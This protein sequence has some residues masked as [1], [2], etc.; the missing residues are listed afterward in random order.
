MHKDWY[1]FDEQKAFMVSRP[2]TRV[3]HEKIPPGI[4]SIDVSPKGLWF[5]PRTISAD[6]SHTLPEN[7]SQKVI[8]SVRNFRTKKDRYD[9]K[10]L[11]F[12][13]TI[14][15]EGP[16]GSG[17]TTTLTKVAL[18]MVSEGYP[19]IWGERPQDIGYAVEELRRLEPDRFVVGIL[20]DAD[21]FNDDY[22]LLSMLDGENRVN[23]VVYLLTTNFLND[24]DARLTNRPSRIDEIVTIGMPEEATREAFF[25]RS[26]EDE[27]FSKISLERLV[28]DSEGMSIAHLKE[29]VV[30]VT[31][32]DQPY[33]GVIERL[34]KMNAEDMEE[35]EED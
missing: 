22:Y 24:M 33:E 10:G 6:R 30:A 14:L 21:R 16:P 11:L 9:R 2:D 18:E 12:K 8:E 25:L 29:M 32:L 26:L 15:M 13:R 1:W 28:K 34:K 3:K 35:Q 31:V 7:N 4:Y 5:N 20:E 23:N 17:K 19:V 27:D